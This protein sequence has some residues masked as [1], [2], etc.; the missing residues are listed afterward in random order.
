MKNQKEVSSALYPAEGFDAELDGGVHLSPNLEPLTF[1]Q[2][3][4]A[5]HSLLLLSAEIFSALPHQVKGH[6]QS[7]L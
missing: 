6:L 2:S 7:M 4:L 1:P 5:T 3:S